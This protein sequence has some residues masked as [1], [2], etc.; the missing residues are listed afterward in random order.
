LNENDADLNILQKLTLIPIS[1]GNEPNTR[2]ASLCYALEMQGTNKKKFS[3]VKIECVKKAK[4]ICMIEKSVSYP[5]QPIP[6]FPCPAE[7]SVR[8]EQNATRRNKREEELGD[9]TL[10]GMN[11]RFDECI[12]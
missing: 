8:T 7:Q 6:K 11:V 4:P 3:L 12:K 10:K 5:G 2:A 9:S 1:V